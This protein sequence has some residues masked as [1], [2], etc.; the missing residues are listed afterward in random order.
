MQDIAYKQKYLK[1]KAKY[2]ELKRGGGNNLKFEEIKKK[3]EEIKK[4]TESSNKLYFGSNKKEILEISQKKNKD[5]NDYLSIEYQFIK[6]G[7]IEIDTQSIPNDNF[8]KNRF[9][10]PTYNVQIK[11]NEKSEYILTICDDCAGIDK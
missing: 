8:F 2:L 11:L 4:K 1:Y 7:K 5:N 10:D 3:F 9:N 6:E